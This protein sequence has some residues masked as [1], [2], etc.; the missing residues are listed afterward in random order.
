MHN[1]EQESSQNKATRRELTSSKHHKTEGWHVNIMH[2]TV[3]TAKEMAEQCIPILQSCRWMSLMINEL[4]TRIVTP[5]CN[6]ASKE[7]SLKFTSYE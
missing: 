7:I 4:I 3:V 5:S 6:E 1:V 2:K